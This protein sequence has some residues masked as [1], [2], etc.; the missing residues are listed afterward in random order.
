[1]KGGIVGFSQQK[2]SCPVNLWLPTAHKHS[3]IVSSVKAMCETNDCE[4]TTVNQRLCVKQ[5]KW[6]QYQGMWQ[7]TSWER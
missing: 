4:P 2:D 1:M 5:R 3:N 7:R 6:D